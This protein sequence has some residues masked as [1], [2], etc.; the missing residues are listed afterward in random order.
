MLGLA[1]QSGVWCTML[2]C[3]RRWLCR[4]WSS[5]YAHTH[6][7]VPTSHLL[8][9]IFDTALLLSLVPPSTP[10]PL[11]WCTS[12]NV[13]GAHPTPFILKD[14][15]VVSQ[16][17]VYTS[18]SIFQWRV[19]T[20]I[21]CPFFLFSSLLLSFLSAIHKCHFS[22]ERMRL[23]S[24]LVQIEAPGCRNTSIPRVTSPWSYTGVCIRVSL[25]FLIFFTSYYSILLTSFSDLVLVWFELGNTAKAMKFCE[26]ALKLYP[27]DAA[28]ALKRKVQQASG[29]S[30]Q[31][32]AAKPS[33]RVR[34]VRVDIIFK[35]SCNFCSRLYSPPPPHPYFRV[36]LKLILL[37][38]QKLCHVHWKLSHF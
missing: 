25:L 10:S 18:I 11:H 14:G 27:T 15:S 19:T 24:F 8:L 17:D 31:S 9:N 1:L 34:A 6:T 29:G 28:R 20:T 32:G 38:T 21:H 5:V 16:D 4:R 2:L 37:V 22:C 35:W 23:R 26:K 3:A 13:C 33:Q 7:Q 30:G 36:L 12:T